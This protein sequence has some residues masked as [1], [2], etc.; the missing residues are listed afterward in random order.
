MDAVDIYD[1]AVEYLTQHPE[2]IPDAYSFSEET[3][4]GALFQDVTP[5]GRHDFVMQPGFKRFGDL[6]SIKRD[7]RYIAPTQQLTDLIRFDPRLPKEMEDISVAMLTV[8][9][10][11]QRHLDKIIPRKKRWEL[12]KEVVVPQDDPLSEE[13]EDEDEEPEAATQDSASNEAIGTEA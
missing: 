5:T 2:K 12:P 1:E 6:V 10:E 3:M 13:T 8:F 4:G 11:W 9:A 7:E